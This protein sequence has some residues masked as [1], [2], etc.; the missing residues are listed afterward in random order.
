MLIKIMT[1][2]SFFLS[3]LIRSFRYS[4]LFNFS[5]DASFKIKNQWLNSREGQFEFCPSQSKKKTTSVFKFVSELWRH[6]T[7]TSRQSGKIL[8]ENNV[9]VRQ[10]DVGIATFI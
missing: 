5:P 8:T 4:M 10:V 3:H 6:I 2:T 9:G 1:Y 7:S